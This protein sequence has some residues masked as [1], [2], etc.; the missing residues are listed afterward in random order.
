MRKI[1]DLTGQRFGRLT[2]IKIIGRTNSGL[3]KWELKCDC[4][5]KTCASTGSL[6]IGDVNSCGC[7][8]KEIVSKM[9][10]THNESKTRLYKIWECMKSRCNNINDTGYKWYGGRNIK[11]CSE[12]QD[13]I[14]FRNWALINGYVV[15]LTI[16]RIDFNKDYCPENCRWATCK[17]QCN[18]TRRN[19]YITYNNKTQT[20]AQWSEELKISYSTLSARINTLKWTIEKSFNYR[21]DVD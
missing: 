3:I 2:A 10:T 5:N 11:I 9:F 20:L 14:N 12:W 1:I 4:G 13:Y 7:L 18:N 6:R 16:E 19:K 8:H 21:K 17:E 15:G